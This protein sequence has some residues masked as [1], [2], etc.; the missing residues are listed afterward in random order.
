MPR[1]D[2]LALS[3]SPPL[4]LARPKLDSAA[5][6]HLL[7]LSIPLSLALSHGVVA[8]EMSDMELDAPDDISSAT[9]VALLRNIS[10]NLRLC[11]PGARFDQIEV[12]LLSYLSSTGIPVSRRD[13]PTVILDKIATRIS[14]IEASAAT[15]PASPKRMGMAKSSA[16]TLASPS[17]RQALPAG[18]ASSSSSASTSHQR[19]DPGNHTSAS[20]TASMSDRVLH[21]GGALAPLAHASNSV[22]GRFTSRATSRPCDR[23][24]IGSQADTAMG[25]MEQ[26]NHASHQSSVPHSALGVAS[27]S[28]TQGP[29]DSAAEGSRVASSS[30]DADQ[31]ASLTRQPHINE[32]EKELDTSKGQARK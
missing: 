11:K 2:G 23:A 32:S 16:Y 15:P 30:R 8:A 27:S 31:Q 14:N 18:E 25:V 4:R 13:S 20:S 17:R 5:S 28:R 19:L 21:S 3:V 10:H 29:S 26:L 7:L 22:R 9:E 12:D 6:L 24:V 1:F